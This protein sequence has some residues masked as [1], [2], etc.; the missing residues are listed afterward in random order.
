MKGYDF[1]LLQKGD[2]DT[3]TNTITQRALSDLRARFWRFLDQHYPSVRRLDVAVVT[4]S[5]LFSLIPLHDANHH[6]YLTMCRDIID[7]VGISQTVKADM[8]K[9]GPDRELACAM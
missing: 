8:S 4:A 9:F 6:R 7:E 5:L 3:L 2:T 1:I